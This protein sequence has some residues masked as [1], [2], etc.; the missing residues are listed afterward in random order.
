MPREPSMILIKSFYAFIL[1]VSDS[2]LQC[3]K[4]NSYWYRVQYQTTTLGQSVY[5]DI[6]NYYTFCISILFCNLIIVEQ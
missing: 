2:G 6:G 3:N 4:H 5:P 1:Y